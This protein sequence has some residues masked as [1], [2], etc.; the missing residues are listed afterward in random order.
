MESYLVSKGT[1]GFTLQVETLYYECQNQNY[2]AVDF[3]KDYFRSWDCPD[4]VVKSYSESEIQ[5]ILGERRIDIR[6]E[7]VDFTIVGYAGEAG[8]RI[9]GVGV[10]A[11]VLL[12]IIEI[13]YEDGFA[14]SGVVLLMKELLPKFRVPNS[15]NVRHYL[16]GEQENVRRFDGYDSCMKELQL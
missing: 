11:D 16:C 2:S 14:D 9:L 5:S 6:G 1:S 15:E 7:N 12:Y 8:S 3:I 10:Y 13:G 4:C